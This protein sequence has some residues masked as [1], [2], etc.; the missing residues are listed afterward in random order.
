[1]NLFI[2]PPFVSVTSGLNP[3]VLNTST[4]VQLWD[5]LVAF[6]K[7]NTGKSFLDLGHGFGNIALLAAQTGLIVHGVEREKTTHA[8]AMQNMY[9][10][11][12]LRYITG[13]TIELKF[14]NFEQ[15]D[16]SSYDI[17]YHYGSMAILSWLVTT[18]RGLLVLLPHGADGEIPEKVREIK[19]FGPNDEFKVYSINSTSSA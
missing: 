10:A 6:F 8:I 17:L 18:Y 2:G 19:Q 12:E 11:I 3:A 7:Q 16:L 4:P 9:A 13:E 15:F 1:M 14:G 5:D